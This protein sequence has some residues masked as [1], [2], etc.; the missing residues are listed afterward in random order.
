M[1]KDI[2]V[3]VLQ[4][5]L[6]CLIEFICKFFN[7]NIMNEKQRYIYVFNKICFVFFNLENKNIFYKGSIMFSTIMHN[8]L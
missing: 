1:N 5:V 2:I 3:L 7:K 4:R 8:I 6:E